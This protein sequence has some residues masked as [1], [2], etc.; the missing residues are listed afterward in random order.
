MVSYKFKIQNK[1]GLH[2]RPAGKLSEIACRFQSQIHII[3][4]NGRAN[5]KS[6][7]SLLAAGLLD[8]ESAELQCEGPDEAAAR[9]A[10]QSFIQSELE[11][12][13]AA[14]LQD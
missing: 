14:E 10:L 8:G 5:A 13:E 9:E 6:V 11:T 3:A 2:L 1:I 12:R 4:D 7:L